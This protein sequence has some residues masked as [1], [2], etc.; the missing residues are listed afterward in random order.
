MPVRIF[1]CRATVTLINDNKVKEITRQQLI[2]I[3]ACLTVTTT[4]F[5]LLIQAEKD[6]LG[7][8]DILVINLLHCLGKRLK[9]FTHGLVN[10]D[11][12]VCQIKNFLE[13]TSFPESIND[14]EAGIGFACASSHNNQD[15][16]GATHNRFYSTIDSNA[17]I[18]AWLL[19][20]RSRVIR[21]CI[22]IGFFLCK[23]RLFLITL[24]Q[25]VR[26]REIPNFHGLIQ[27]GNHIFLNKVNTIGCVGKRDI[28]NVRIFN[29][30]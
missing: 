15:T 18:I 16:L 14:L 23:L 25:L 11:I 6:F 1:R 22:D 7:C 10:Q 24:P 13:S 28:Q 20:S 30:L 19:S 9:I 17:L 3:V 4:C 29:S 12:A 5:K 21:I 27:T 2:I 26:S 8:V